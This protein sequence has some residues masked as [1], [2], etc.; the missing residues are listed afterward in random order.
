MIREILFFIIMLSMGCIL[1]AISDLPKDLW[2][3][4]SMLYYLVIQKIGD[5]VK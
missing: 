3:I 4:Y 1:C 2:L 5:K